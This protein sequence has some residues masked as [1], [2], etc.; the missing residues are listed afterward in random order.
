MVNHQLS[1]LA[2]FDAYALHQCFDGRQVAHV[3]GHV[4]RQNDANKPLAEGLEVVARKALHEI[5]IFLIEYGEGFCDMEILLHGLVTKH[6]GTVRNSVNVVGI[7]HAIVGVV[8]ADRGDH[9]REDVKLRQ[10]C[11]LDEVSLCHDNVSHFEYI[12]S[13]QVIVVSN[14]SAVA[15]VNLTQKAGELLVG[16]I[17]GILEAKFEEDV[18]GQYRELVFATNLL[19]IAVDVEFWSANIAKYIVVVVEVDHDGVE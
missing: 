7:C 15:L 5:K 16:D 9:Q 2:S 12:S 18:Q 4:S 13:V 11:P 3:L 8:V 19:R 10:P 1:I 14:I 6:D 17:I